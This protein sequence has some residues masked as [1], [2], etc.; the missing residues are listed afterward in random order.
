MKL[1][2]NTKI[3]D[4][5]D[6]YPFLLDFLLTESPRFK[7]LQSAVMRNT[8]GKVA[9]LTQAS[10]MGDIPLEKLVSDI[11]AHI[12]ART[13]E[14]ILIEGGAEP[15]EAAGAAA[16]QET[17]KS[18]IRDLHRGEDISLLKRR[19]HD[20]IKD[21]GPSEI[22]ALEQKLIEEGMPEQEIK[23][24]CDVHVEVF[25]E[26]LEK[27]QSPL[28]PPGH[29][30][31]TFMLENKEAVRLTEHLASVLN[32]F[33]DA[34]DT[35]LFKQS[36]QE[37]EDSIALL[38]DINLHYLRKENQLFPVLEEHGISGP[39]EVIWAIHDDIRA[40]LKRSKAQVAALPAS[41]ALQILQELVKAIN[42]MAYKEDHILFPMSLEVLSDADWMKVRAGEDEIG[43]AWIKPE[44]SWISG[45]ARIPVKEKLSGVQ[46]RLELSTGHLSPEQVNLI[47]THLPVEI[48]FVN[49]HDEVEYYSGV[50]DKIFPRSPGIIGRKVQ[51]CHP[52]KSLYMVQKI[53]D[54]FRAGTKDVADFWIQ[55]KGKFICI[56]Y[57][58]VRDAQGNYKGTMEVVQDV[59]HIRTL[60]GQKRLLDWT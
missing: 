10:T 50:K 32:K 6:K 22:A 33:C 48:S 9:T 35:G 40:M 29:P 8:V 42:D 4:L 58:A 13:G 20:L 19:F 57:Y 15:E 17:L 46:A 41:D 34:G 14:K 44:A 47:L 49:E 30:V 60:S 54:E 45:D 52:P 2:G 16:R 31:H 39:T 38:S 28:V 36:R 51:N 1:N 56:T 3:Q 23:R 55:M 21:I 43:Y 12:E 26:S 5:L 53:L 27:K 7:L 59:T 18:I 24:L 25:R 11:A 37:I